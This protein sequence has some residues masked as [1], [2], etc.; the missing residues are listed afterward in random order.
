MDTNNPLKVITHLASTVAGEPH[1]YCDCYVAFLDILGFKQMIIEK[2]PLEIKSIFDEVRKLKRLLQHPKIHTMIAQEVRDKMEITILSD[3]IIISIPSHE[4]N[5]FICLFLACLNIQFMFTG[6]KSPVLIRGSITKGDFFR[7]YNSEDSVLMTFGPSLN[8]AYFFQEN[9]ALY[10]RIIMDESL[11]Q[12]EKEKLKNGNLE[13]FNGFL[14]NDSDG[15]WF[16]DYLKLRFLG[17]HDKC[18]HLKYYIENELSHCTDQRILQK[19]RW[20]KKYYN[21]ALDEADISIDK[22]KIRIY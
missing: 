14:C 16:I 8:E 21:K 10:P 4:N 5:A 11:V 17:G 2:S 19:I 13:L 20:L 9:I 22:T 6:I 7:Y 3:S 12:T 15:Y 18:N 1:N